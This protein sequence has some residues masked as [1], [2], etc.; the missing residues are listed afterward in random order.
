MTCVKS[1]VL[2]AFMLCAF[3]TSA[4]AL[5]IPSTQAH[6]MVDNLDRTYLLYRPKDLSKEKPVPL[7]IFLHGGFGRGLQAEHTYNWDA[8]ADKYGFVVVYPDGMGRSWNAGGDCCGPA[9]RDNVDDVSFITQLIRTISKSENIDGKRVYLAG[10]SNGA[11]MSYRYACEGSYPI[12]AIGSV[13]GGLS[14]VCE[15]PHPV[16][17]IEV[18]GIEDQNIPLGGGMGAKG[19]AK[20][21]WLSAQKNLDVFRHANG[22]ELDHLEKG[23]VIQKVVSDCAA[24]KKVE[25]IAIEGAG[26]QWPG[27]QPKAR[28]V[29][30]LL[31]IDP[32]STALDAT[33]TLW[34]FF[35]NQH[36]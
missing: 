21:Q 28:F 15:H 26:H 8:E 31:D 9:A 18:H 11:A 30:K 23:T 25:L 3:I 4:H 7:V 22:C 2:I 5:D 20:V 19:V 24:G 35:Q 36:I 16:S 13:S 33:A 34:K 10:M 14:Y 12:A 27:S 1:V 32:P 17:V 6:L 29:D